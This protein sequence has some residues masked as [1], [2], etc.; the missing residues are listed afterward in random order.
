MFKQLMLP[1]EALNR[2]F[3]LSEEQLETSRRLPAGDAARPLH[4][5]K[6][7][8]LGLLLPTNTVSELFQDLAYCRLPNTPAA[9]VG[10]ANVRGDIVPLFD[11]NKLFRMPAGGKHHWRFLIVRNE[12]EEAVGI[13]V[14]G[15]PTRLTLSTRNKLKTLPLLPESLRPHV[16]ACYQLDNIWVEWDI[17]S[18]FGQ[19]S[20]QI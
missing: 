2:A 10:M 19:L 13:R 9:L 14:E 17:F 16:R 3:D 20:R 5:F 6:V 4:G 18:C 1:S 15:L 7:G 11:L 12:D 8:N